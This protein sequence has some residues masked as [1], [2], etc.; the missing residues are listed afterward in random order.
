MEAKHCNAR[1]HTALDKGDVASRTEEK[2]Q[3]TFRILSLQR[4]NFV[5][6]VFR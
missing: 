1:L 2:T 3:I 5:E 4:A 6:L